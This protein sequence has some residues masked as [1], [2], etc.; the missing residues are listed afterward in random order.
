MEW[1]GRWLQTKRRVPGRARRWLWSLAREREAIT[2][3]N[4]KQ[5][6]KNAAETASL[7]YSQP[8]LV[9]QT[10]SPFNMK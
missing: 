5:Q 4:N 10:D 2:S 1:Y 8:V 3:N 7:M 6:Q 9:K